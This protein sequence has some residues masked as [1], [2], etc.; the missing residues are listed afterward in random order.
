LPVEEKLKLYSDD[1]SKTMRLSRIYF[2]EVWYS[3]W[4]YVEAVKMKI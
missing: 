4:R 2:L 3:S 1:P